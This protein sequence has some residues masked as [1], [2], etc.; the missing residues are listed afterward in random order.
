MLVHGER[1]DY[2]MTEHLTRRA[3]D[4]IEEMTLDPLAREVVGHL[5]DELLIA[6]RDRA[7][8][9]EPRLVGRLGEGLSQSSCYR[10]A[11][12]LGRCLGCV[13]HPSSC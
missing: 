9:S 6:E 5:D 3:G 10:L 11:E 2:V 4:K 13:H 1:D 8:M 7:R 12:V